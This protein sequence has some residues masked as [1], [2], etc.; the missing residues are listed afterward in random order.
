MLR[1]QGFSM[2]A[3]PNQTIFLPKQRSKEGDSACFHRSRVFSTS[4]I[5]RSRAD[6]GLC[7]LKRGAASG[8]RP[9]RFTVSRTTFK[10]R[11][12]KPAV[13]LPEHLN[14]NAALAVSVA[15]K[16]IALIASCHR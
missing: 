16:V 2:R 6:Q 10:T 3:I 9:K 14:A 4:R 15:K 11:S 8:E 13:V 7:V 1:G 5:P 12:P